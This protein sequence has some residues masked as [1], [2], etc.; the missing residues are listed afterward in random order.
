[1]AAPTDTNRT[2]TVRQQAQTPEKNKQLLV[3]AMIVLHAKQEHKQ[4]MKSRQP[5]TCKSA[6]PVR[7][8]L[9]TSTRVQ[10]TIE[11]GRLLLLLLMSHAVQQVRAVLHLAHHSLLRRRSR[12]GGAKVAASTSSSVA[13]GSTCSPSRRALAPPAS[14]P[15][16]PPGPSPSA[17]LWGAVASPASSSTSLMLRAGTRARARP[18][19]RAASSFSLMPPTCRCSAR[20]A[21]HGSWCHTSELQ[22][23]VTCR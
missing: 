3:L 16:S 2:Q 15:S 23:T 21:Q 11:G 5:F 13:T 9:E 14:P 20:A 19:A 4:T 22:S 10:E 17:A 12:Y 7:L 6:H 1:M 18:A 8:H